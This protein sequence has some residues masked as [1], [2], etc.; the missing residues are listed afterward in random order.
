M[1]VFFR[2][3]VDTKF[4]DGDV[5]WHILCHY[6]TES[7]SASDTQVAVGI[8]AAVCTEITNAADTCDALIIAVAS[9]A[10]TSNASDTQAA[11]REHNPEISESSNAADAQV[12]IKGHNPEIS[13]SSNVADTSGF[14]GEYNAV[15]EESSSVADT[16]NGLVIRIASIAEAS[17]VSDTPVAQVDYNAVAEEATNVAVAHHSYFVLDEMPPAMHEALID[18]YSGGAWLW[19]VEVNLPGYPVM[20]LVKNPRDVDY[21]GYT[22]KAFNFENTI[23]RL[24][25]DGTVAQTTIRIVQDDTYSLEHKINALEG[26]GGSIR[27]IRAHE[28]FLEDSITELEYHSP[29]QKMGSDSKWV[30]FKTGVPDPLK[31]TA[32]LRRNTNKMCPYADPSLFKGPECQYGGG[33]ATC[34][35]LYEDCFDKNNAE[36]W[37]GELCLQNESGG[38]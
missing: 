20:R 7:A 33:D 36:H 18:P 5:L 31:K 4:V 25:A 16:H 6:V 15:A 2:N 38:V 30:V 27:L 22:W 8:Y 35:G 28:D 23:P 34:T 11:L 13:E 1:S 37:G 14:G 3:T 19:F 21:I 12:A 32:P 9:I 10:E 29:I 26:K 17:N 24:N